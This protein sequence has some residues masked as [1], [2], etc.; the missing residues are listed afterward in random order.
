MTNLAEITLYGIKDVAEFLGIS[1]PVANR[2]C[3]ERIIKAK[4]VGREWKVTKEGLENYLNV[5]RL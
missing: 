2:M 3:R 1:I 5:R 4:K